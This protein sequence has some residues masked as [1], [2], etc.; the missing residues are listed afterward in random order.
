MLLGQRLIHDGA[1]RGGAA[2]ALGA[3]AEGAV[4]LGRRAWAVR[5]RVEAG[6]HLAVRE[7][8]ARADDHGNTQFGVASK[9][10]VSGTLGRWGLATPD[11]TGGA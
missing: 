3:A 6:A 11:Y 4:D 1:D 8:I 10:M 9:A 5:T 7:D 2:P